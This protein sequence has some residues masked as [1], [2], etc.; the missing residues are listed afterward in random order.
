MALL[1]PCY[2]DACGAL[3][4][5][6]RCPEHRPKHPTK[7]R[8]ARGYGHWWESLSRQ[9]RELQ[10]WCSTCL[11]PGTHTNP[12]TVDHTP[13]AWAKVQAGKRLTL[14]DFGLGLLSVECLR[15]NVGKGAARGESVD[16]V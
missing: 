10:P 16:R 5:K 8:K 7:D 11:T 6:A 14:K 1:K 9:A 4:E 12:L 15:C 13:A 2:I 3:S